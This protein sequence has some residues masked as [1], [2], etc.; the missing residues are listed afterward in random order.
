MEWMRRGSLDR[1]DDL[2]VLFISR[3]NVHS[4]WDWGQHRFDI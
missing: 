2:G 4:I 1:D 3:K